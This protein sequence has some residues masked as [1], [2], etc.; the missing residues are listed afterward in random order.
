MTSNSAAE[1]A[2]ELRDA[3]NR[4]NRLYYIDQTPEM[5]DAEWDALF[6][7]LRTLEADHPELLTPDSPTQRVGAPP[8]ARFA[9]V[10]HPSPMLSLG[11]VF[12]R[13]E[14][15]AWWR[16]VS[17]YVEV[18]RFDM[19]CELKID[20]LAV[21]LRYE[22]AVL[23]RAA[24][25]GDGI[26]GEDVTANIRTIR[27][28]P[29]RLTGDDV[30]AMLEV[31][32][33]VFFPISAFEQFNAERETQGLPTY[34][35]PRNSASGALRQLDSSETASRPLDAFIYSIPVSDGDIPAT[36]S[37]VLD[38]LKRWGFK[39]HPW[40]RVAADL[41]E[42]SAV[43]E[44][45]LTIRPELDHGIDGVVIKV[46]DLGLQARLGT[47]GRD[48]RW[49]TAWKFPAEQATTRLLKIGINVG[50]TGSLNP[51]AILDP[52]FVGG[53]TVSQA[54]LHNADVIAEKDVR[55]GD[56]V[57]VQRAGDVI[58][59]VVGPAP[60]NKRSPDSKPFEMPGF[61]PACESE[62]FPDGEDVVIRCVNGRCPAQTVRLLGH[63]A[64]R[65]AMDIEG[66]GEKLVAVLYEQGFVADVADIFDLEGKRDELI[67]LDRMGEISVKNL[68]EA[69]KGAK[70]QPLARLITGLGIPHV[71]SENAE[72][73]AGHF[74]SLDGMIDASLHACIYRNIPVEG[75]GRSELIKNLTGIEGIGPTIAESLQDWLRLES[76]LRILRNLA[77]HGVEP[78]I[79][80]RA[81]KDLRFAGL[82]FVVTGRLDSLS[83]QEAQGK[84]KELGGAVSSSVSGRT[85]FVVVGAD[86]GSK[87]DSAVRLNV[88]VL[89]EGQFLKFLE[90]EEP[91][92]AAKLPE[93]SEGRSVDREES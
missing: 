56:L 47:V 39:T 80:E 12:D 22:G 67:A 73:I 46:D 77:A 23:V 93:Q 34:V 81:T 65:G 50:R 76:N 78:P 71:G 3:L 37:G 11:N 66:L 32:G 53:V 86:P 75:D 85:N 64:S 15:E 29:L 82:R 19:T 6:R 70:T 30:P 8:S 49:A 79:A 7:E 24:T 63:F 9:E 92:V 20:G 54:T 57:I 60:G 89:D 68:L 59:Q 42:V 52:V 62:V 31:R 61:C 58:P 74:R 40:S 4:A 18:D 10:V 88:P 1:R 27:T 33:E 48:P 13:E 43:F 84:I 25:R 2:A 44:D 90:G 28:V 21:A 41:D 87:Y 5:S 38:A 16:R 17:E 51:Y 45:A 83:R 26:R 36:Q 91:D 55:E 72:L 69:I 14:L 35:N